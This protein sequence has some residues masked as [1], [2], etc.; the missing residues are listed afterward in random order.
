[1]HTDQPTWP[2]VVRPTKYPE[3]YA[4]RFRKWRVAH[5][6][7][8]RPVRVRPVAPAWPVVVVSPLPGCPALPEQPPPPAPPTYRR[9]SWSEQLTMWQLHDQGL[10]AR[11]IGRRLNPCRDHHTVA[12]WL[13]PTRG[14]GLAQELALLGR[15]RD[16]RRMVSRLDGSGRA[17]LADF[18]ALLPRPLYRA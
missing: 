8:R 9:V 4:R 5:F 13:T 16:L 6:G 15:R 10:S 3:S 14:L 12:R 1:M 7:R 18:L 17:K 2:P 11:E